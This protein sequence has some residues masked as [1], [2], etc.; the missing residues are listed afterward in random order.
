MGWTECEDGADGDAT[1][2]DESPLTEAEIREFFLNNKKRGLLSVPSPS[3]RETAF[4][5]ALSSWI[6]SGPPVMRRNLLEKEKKSL[7]DS[8]SS[9]CSV[10]S[11]FSHPSSCGM[12][13]D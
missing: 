9:I 12:D 2:S 11:D 4:R 10:S 7:N 8:S 6:L 1:G 13:S 3:H 5:D